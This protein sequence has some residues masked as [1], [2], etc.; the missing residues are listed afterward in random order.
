M[1]LEP[2]LV[3]VVVPVFDTESYVEACLA[4][5]LSQDHTALQVV[6]VDD[7]ST[8]GS[9]EV[10]RR[11]A[12]TD[13]RVELLTQPNGGLGAARNTGAGAARGEFL[14]FVDSDDT[15]PA[16][17]Y[18]QMV[19]S[20]EHSGSEVCVGRLVRIRGGQVVELPWAER[21][22]ARTRLGVSVASEPRVLR[23]FYTPNKLY[24][25]DFWRRHDFEF[26]EVRLFED[27]P[28]ITRLLCAA[29]GIDV[30][31]ETTYHWLSRQDRS[32]L[33]QG[34]YTP[35]NVARR[36]EA[37]ALTRE[38]L[39]GQPPAV[40]DAWLWTLLDGHFPNYLP[41]ERSSDP[42]Q[43]AAV[44]GMIA[45]VVDADDVLRISDV[46]AE[47]RVMA[48][49]AVTRG[50][51]A[52]L[53]FVGQ[54]GRREQSFP[55]GLVAER[56]TVFLPTYDDPDLAVPTS[57]FRLAESQLVLRSWL[58]GVA[59][60][61][62]G[63]LEV[64]ARAYVENV[65][66]TH[67]TVTVA[68]E[69]VGDPS[70]SSVRVEA[71]PVP[72]ELAGPTP[73]HRRL[74]YAGADVLARF[75]AGFLARNPEWTLTLE[76][77]GPG[78]R[79][80][81]RAW[82]PVVEAMR[83]LEVLADLPGGGRGSVRLEG[84]RLRVSLGPVP[85]PDGDR[86]RPEAVLDR[87]AVLD[88]ALGL[89][90]VLPA[91]FGRSVSLHLVGKR[92][93]GA[94]PVVADVDP[95]GRFTA[96]L[97]L[98]RTRWGHAETLPPGD[99][100]LLLGPTGPCPEDRPPAGARIPWTLAHLPGVV[101]PSAPLHPGYEQAF[102]AR[103]VPVRGALNRVVLRVP[104]G[105]GP[106]QATPA[107]R[108]AQV[109]RW[110]RGEFAPR[111]VAPR[112]VQ[113]RDTVLLQGDRH[114]PDR[115]L[116]L[117]LLAALRRTHPALEV[118]WT[119]EDTSGPVPAGARAVLRSHASWFEAWATSRFVVSDS[120]PGTF[121]GQPGQRVVSVLGDEHE[122]LGTMSRALVDL[123]A[124]Q[125]LNAQRVVVTPGPA[126]TRRATSWPGVRVLEL[127]DPRNDVLLDASTGDLRTRTRS[128]L[129]LERDRVLLSRWP[130]SCWS[131]ARALPV[132]TVLVHTGD[133]GDTWC[134]SEDHPDLT[135]FPHERALVLAADAVLVAQGRLPPGYH[136]TTLEVREGATAT[137]APVV[138]DLRLRPHDDGR[139]SAAVVAA[140]LG[141]DAVRTR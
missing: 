29:T 90:G 93:I 43:V 98:R 42:A 46:A 77:V 132:G 133:G 64:R 17:T 109:R 59:W 49:L 110:F 67:C 114:R 14:A 54:G 47:N 39:H 87:F 83:D 37:L 5:V 12:A 30:L 71:D 51:D 11:L 9:R 25:T 61:A 28:L 10:V 62:E 131:A 16:S 1:T 134:G 56:P 130:G 26:R 73:R 58:S 85:E 13:P 7:G 18:S 80:T 122:S 127:G 52:V 112:E 123:A 24:R 41:R 118:L 44:V 2:G 15:V 125:P 19:A 82:P 138:R 115:S 72:A 36:V 88:G 34:M 139:V 22:H 60:T 65:D 4:S 35:V 107:Y 121:L 53:E 136:H 86:F 96:R 140:V 74:G 69:P 135:G 31:A 76:V 63:D 8:D 81:T 55:V 100:R 89:S 79:R 6:V 68:L 84:D 126:L 116:E 129:G 66:P 119:V 94:D 20:L 104:G 124:E 23:D 40:L 50:P 102:D 141:V 113:L 106:D 48:W 70:G 92:P 128:R 75:P 95:Q 3:S 117:A 91:P 105:L 33:S 99:Y 21:L 101:S 32:S 120:V 103:V 78:V 137:L 45:G 57:A 108:Q 38:A 111:G 97:P 27:Q